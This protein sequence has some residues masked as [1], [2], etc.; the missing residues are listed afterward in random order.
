MKKL[1]FIPVL[2]SALM[3]FQIC[4]YKP[5]MA[6]G[7]TLV[8]GG[9]YATGSALV[10][11]FSAL[12]I[13][14]ENN[15]EINPA[16]C[17]KLIDDCT[18]YL[19]DSKLVKDVKIGTKTVS[20]LSSVCYALSKGAQF[21][22]MYLSKSFIDT[23]SR[24][25]IDNGYTKSE[26][27]S[28][29]GSSYQEVQIIDGLYKYSGSCQTTFSDVSA[30]TDTVIYTLDESYNK[31]CIVLNELDSSTK[32]F[33]PYIDYS[34]TPYYLLNNSLKICFN[35]TRIGYG[36]GQSAGYITGT[37]TFN[38]AIFKNK[39]DALNYL[40]DGNLDGIL[41]K[42]VVSEWYP[43]TNVPTKSAVGDEVDATGGLAWDKTESFPVSVGG[44]D[45]LVDAYPVSVPNTYE[46][47][48][49]Y[50]VAGEETMPWE[51]IKEWLKGLAGTAE[52]AQTAVRTG[53][54]SDAQYDAIS[55]TG[56]DA[57]AIENTASADETQGVVGTLVDW[58][59]N[60]INPNTGILSKFPFS[61]TYD[62]YLI[63][64][65][66]SGGS[67]SSYDVDPNNVTVQTL[68]APSGEFE[69]IG[70]DINYSGNVDF[71]FTQLPIDLNFD[72]FTWL[73]NIVKFGIGV[74]WL[75]GLLF[76][77][78]GSWGKSNGGDE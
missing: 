37:S 13:I 71:G 44:V 59:I 67:A 39:T 73:F 32:S 68:E 7:E 75:F 14:N 54:L 52:D 57:K 65:S 12:G 30:T 25:A 11:A 70:S 46:G 35:I 76:F 8:L 24:W 72:K 9:C 27:I 10:S 33:Y 19:K 38:C 40:K 2:L 78:G 15:I 62:A 4:I 22:I 53:T 28:N 41:N 47:V 45:S 56:T 63:V 74:L 55:D 1:R 3:V 36:S 42:G 66:I 51:D 48:E 18:Q 77:V 26:T 34:F 31:M 61:I 5:V 60:L 43:A 50:P 49:T 64:N 58:G 23:I 29:I 20:I 21:N 6:S 16:N 17:Q 69:I